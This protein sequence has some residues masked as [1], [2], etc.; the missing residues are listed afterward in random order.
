MKKKLRSGHNY[1][2]PWYLKNAQHF[3]INHGETKM[4]KCI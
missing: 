2:D 1:A 4:E 3:T